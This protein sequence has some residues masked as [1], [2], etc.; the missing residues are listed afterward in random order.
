[1]IF[2][3]HHP[4]LWLRDHPHV[5]AP[6]KVASNRGRRTALTG[7]PTAKKR[8]SS[9]SKKREAPSR[10]SSAKASKKKKTTVA[11]ASGSRGVVIQEVTI[12]D[13]LPVEESAAQG[14]SAPVSKKPIKKHQGW[15][16]NLCSPC[17]PKRVNIHC[18][19]RCCM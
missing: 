6:G 8:Q 19:T 4:S 18:C 16:E 10:D 7:T 17:L 15:E 13:P 14:V 12:Q 11:E 2:G 5:P 9:R 1:M 3:D